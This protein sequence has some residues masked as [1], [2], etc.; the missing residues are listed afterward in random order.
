MSLELQAKSRTDITPTRNLLV[1][2]STGYEN[3]K[4]IRKE[5]T[6][7]VSQYRF[8]VLELYCSL[9]DNLQAGQSLYDVYESWKPD[10]LN[11]TL[12]HHGSDCFGLALLLQRKLREQNIKSYIFPFSTRG[13]LAEQEAKD[14]LLDMGSVG[15]LVEDSNNHFYFVDPGFALVEPITFTGSTQSVSYRLDGRVF[16]LDF[17]SLNGGMMN[18][19]GD[20]G[21]KKQIDFRFNQFLNEEALVELQKRYMR[22]RPTI[23]IERFNEIGEKIAGLKIQLLKDQIVIIHGKDK[24]TIN[25][26]DWDNF[27]HLKIAAELE[28]DATE[29][30]RQV[31]LVIRNAYKLRA[32]WV[33]SL[34]QLYAD[35]NYDP[36]RR[37]PTDWT[38]AKESGY[39][40][41]GVVVLLK[42]DK[43]ELLMYRVPKSREKPHIGRLA[44]QYNVVV[45][46]ADGEEDLESNLS[47]ALYEELGLDAQEFSDKLDLQGYAETTYG[48]SD[49]RKSLAR[50]VVCKWKGDLN[51]PFKF[52]NKVEGGEWEWVPIG[53]VMTCDLEPNIRAI[54]ERHILEGLL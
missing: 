18:V 19:I 39:T 10:I 49:Q 4:T 8:S 30:D 28:V 2:F 24:K 32:L 48:V 36:L 5:A 9:L 20:D 27:D 34:R 13:L 26:T 50:C 52:Q 38:T 44:G 45:E 54:L 51:H 43:D 41:G 31:K 11:Q 6:E 25:F 14:L 47:R 33:P 53:K 1:D 17:S 12:S 7:V 3:A 16:H 21:S 29:L 46:T 40:E 42:N 37:N 23:H 22:V 15:L 35:R